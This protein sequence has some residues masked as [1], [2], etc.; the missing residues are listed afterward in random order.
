MDQVEILRH[1]FQGWKGFVGILTKAT[2]A[3]IKFPANEVEGLKRMQAELGEIVKNQQEMN[4]V[5]RPPAI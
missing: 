4:G 5:Q 2:A 3:G 1:L